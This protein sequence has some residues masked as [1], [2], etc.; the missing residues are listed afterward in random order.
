MQLLFARIVTGAKRGT[1]HN[2]L[3]NDIGW[4]TLEKRR[5]ISKMKFVYK[6]FHG[7]AP[8][9]LVNLLPGIVRENNPYNLRSGDNILLFHNRTET[10]R[11][12]YF[13]IV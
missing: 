9:Y 11:S 7:I 12:H 3:Y 1:S 8:E 5:Y 6:L 13:Q 10:F 4:Q 2:L